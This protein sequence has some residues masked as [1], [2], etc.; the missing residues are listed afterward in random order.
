MSARFA[1][2]TCGEGDAHVGTMRSF[3]DRNDGFSTTMYD[4]G[5]NCVVVCAQC[6]GGWTYELRFDAQARCNYILYRFI[7][8]AAQNGV[9]FRD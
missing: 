8:F 2:A 7:G 1:C 4:T 5:R 6:S 3:L 9:S